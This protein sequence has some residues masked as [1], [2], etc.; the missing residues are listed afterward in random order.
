VIAAPCNYEELDYARVIRQGDVLF[1]CNLVRVAC[2]Q[3]H[4]VDHGHDD[5]NASA[6]DSHRPNCSPGPGHLPKRPGLQGRGPHRRQ[7]FLH[8]GHRLGDN[9]R[10]AGRRTG[11]DVRALFNGANNYPT[12]RWFIRGYVCV[13]PKDM[14]KKATEAFIAEWE[15]RH[16]EQKKASS[17]I[18]QMVMSKYVGKA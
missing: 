4:A 7:A 6:A 3:P 17:A 18:D 11:L 12:H 8:P 5:T 10:G 16:K 15:A 1:D 9:E 2:R 14:D 13:V